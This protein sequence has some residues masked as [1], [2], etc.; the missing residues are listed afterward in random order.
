MKNFF[1]LI[2]V[3]TLLLTVITSCSPESIDE[4]EDPVLIDKRLVRGPNQR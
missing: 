4:K 1:A 3:I 2:V